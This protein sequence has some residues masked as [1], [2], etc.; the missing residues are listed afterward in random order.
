MKQAELDLEAGI[1]ARDEG[2]KAVAE[3]SAPWFERA[4]ACAT[5]SLRPGGSWFTGEDIRQ[6][7]ECRV[8]PPHHSNAFGALI[9]RL[10]RDGIIVPTGRTVPSTRATSHAHRTPEYR[11]A[12]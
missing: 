3:N 11:S 2:M 9:S 5:E 10:V 8:G 1:K 6:W 4:R 7:I 12:R